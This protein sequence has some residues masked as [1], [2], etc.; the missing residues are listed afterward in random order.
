MAR[1]LVRSGAPITGPDRSLLLYRLGETYRV[2]GRTEDAVSA[3]L[4]AIRL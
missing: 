2:L 4:K 3:C 1:D